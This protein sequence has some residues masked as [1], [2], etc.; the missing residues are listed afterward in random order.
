TDGIHCILRGKY[1]G[2][3]KPGPWS[4]LFIAAGIDP[5]RLGPL[6]IV[7]GTCWLLA[8]IFLLTSSSPTAWTVALVVAIASLWSLPLGTV[9][10]IAFILLLIFARSRLVIQ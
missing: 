10:S 1:I 7:F 9:I 6:F 5:F 8:L 3:E 2:P 4:N